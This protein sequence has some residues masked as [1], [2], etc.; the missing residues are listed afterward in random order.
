MNAQRHRTIVRGRIYGATIGDRGEKFYLAVSNN[1]RNARLGDFLA[2]RLTTT[3]KPNYPSIVVLDDKDSDWV[4]SV[5]C[6][7]I[8]PIF[9]EEISRDA[10]ALHP[11]DMQRVDQALRVALS[12]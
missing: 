10:G 9:H 8:E 12:L 3:R 11:K 2:V 7:D 5:L 4:G 6:D 1:S